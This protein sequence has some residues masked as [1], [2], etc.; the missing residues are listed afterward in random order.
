[1]HSTAMALAI[2]F[3]WLKTVYTAI[4]V[5]LLEKCLTVFNHDGFD[6]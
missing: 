4:F 5:E 2:E 3:Q 6:I 1:M